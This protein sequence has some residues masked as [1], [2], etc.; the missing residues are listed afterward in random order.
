MLRV[1]AP[2]PVT[3][4]KLTSR[5]MTESLRSFSAKLSSAG[6]ALSEAQRYNL[7]SFCLKIP[8]FGEAPDESRF[9]HCCFDFRAEFLCFAIKFFITHRLQSNAHCKR[10]QR[11]NNRHKRG[12][13][14]FLGKLF[15]QI[16]DITQQMGVAILNP[17]VRFII[18]TI[19]VD[20]QHSRNRIFSEYRLRK[21]E[22]RFLPN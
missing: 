13:F 17:A 14:D 4:P 12:N 16:L 5:V 19:P 6:F 3:E 22:D 8:E 15:L 18:S 20:N 9:V 1:V 2:A 10:K 11:S 7:C 21:L